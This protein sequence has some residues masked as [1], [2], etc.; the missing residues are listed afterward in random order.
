[1]KSLILFFALLFSGSLFAQDIPIPAGVAGFVE[2]NQLGSPKV[3]GGV[4]ALYPVSGDWRLYM[5]TTALL[6]PQKKLDPTTGKQ[7]YA[8]TTAIR[9]GL[10]RDIVDVGRWSFLFGGDL[11]PAL[12]STSTAGLAL[13]FSS[14]V[15]LTPVYQVNPAISVIMPIRGVYINSVGWNPEID[16]GVQIN[17]NYLTQK[18]ATKAKVKP[19]QHK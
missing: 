16:F 1:M 5:T 2:Y 13:N 11:G 9:Q 8:V 14:S 12:G 3:V 15:V 4:S 19:P 18:A 17:L 10:H 7:F 6:S